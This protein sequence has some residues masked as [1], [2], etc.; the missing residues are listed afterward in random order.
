[1]EGPRSWKTAPVDPL[2]DLTVEEATT[3]AAQVRT[4]HP[5]LFACLK[6]SIHVAF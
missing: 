4:L 1:M 6:L 2:A 5:T 3:A